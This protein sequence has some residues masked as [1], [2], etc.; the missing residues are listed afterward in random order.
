MFMPNHG[1][2]ILKK[3]VYIFFS[4]CLEILISELWAGTEEKK[5]AFRMPGLPLESN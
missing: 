4:D 3:K 1:M 2:T 5:S